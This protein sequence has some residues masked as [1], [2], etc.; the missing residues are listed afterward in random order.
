VTG[1]QQACGFGDFLGR[2]PGYAP[3]KA[4]EFSFS[5]MACVGKLTTRRAQRVLC[6]V[7][8]NTPTTSFRRSRLLAVPV[9]GGWYC[10][11]QLS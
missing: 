3:V 2:E 10:S 4:G 7:Q 6:V 1:G 11:A 8:G 5:R 9:P